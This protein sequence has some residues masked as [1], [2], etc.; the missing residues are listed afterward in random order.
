MQI[1]TLNFGI[2][3]VYWVNYAL[4][5]SSLK[6]AWRIPVILQCVPLLAM[7]CL[8]YVIPESPRWLV[9]HGREKEALEVLS[10]LKGGA[11]AQRH[12]R[13]L[14]KDIVRAVSVQC[15]RG[16]ANWSALWKND[17]LGSRH[18]TLVACGIQA[19]QQLGGIN[20]VICEYPR[21]R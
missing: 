11:L 12:I 19:M 5:F 4:S 13:R 2:A 6:V 10:R 15:Q 8:V 3:L 17:K 1:S 7:L 18:R 21:V 20:A 14:C 16:P 9:S